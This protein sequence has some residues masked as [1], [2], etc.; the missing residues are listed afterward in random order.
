SS[1]YFLYFLPASP[2]PSAGG[3]FRGV[4]D[5][6]AALQGTPSPAR[7]YAAPSPPR[8]AWGGGAERRSDAGGAGAA[9][10]PTTSAPPPRG[11]AGRGGARRRWG[12]VA[13]FSVAAPP[14]PG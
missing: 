9:W 7:C 6:S 4:A 12:T 14:R 2:S 10:G 5:A 1:S 3:C 13:R 11:R 8:S